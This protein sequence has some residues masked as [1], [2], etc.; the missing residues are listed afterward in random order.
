MGVYLNG[1]SV[2]VEEIHAF[3]NQDDGIFLSGGGILRRNTA[4][5]NG[6]NGIVTY[7]CAVLENALQDNGGYGLAAEL[8]VYGSNTIDGDGSPGIAN[9]AAVTQNNNA[10]DGSTC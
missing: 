4:S 10:C 2:L 6:S 3:G 5:L 7:R 8:G 9:F 1:Y